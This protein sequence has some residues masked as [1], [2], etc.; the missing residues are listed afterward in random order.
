MMSLT[1]W[2]ENRWLTDHATSPQE[3]ADLL[4]VVDRDLAD[5]EVD[6]LSADRRLEIAYN[7]AL[8]LSV[9]ALAASGY[10]AVRD[11]AHMYPLRSLEYTIGVEPAVVDT[12]DAVRR[13]RHKTNYERAGTSSHSEAEEVRE[14][15]SDLRERVL[16]WLRAE[17]PELLAAPEGRG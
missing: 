1:T 17:H 2:L 4:A 3:V 8:Q 11:K 13:K 12:L 5:A 14:L 15:A 7:A 6:G 9:L 16:S 10:R